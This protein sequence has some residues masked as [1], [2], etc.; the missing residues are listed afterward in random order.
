[1]SNYKSNLKQQKIKI[2]NKTHGNSTVVQ[3]Q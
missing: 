1:M 3:T 2:K